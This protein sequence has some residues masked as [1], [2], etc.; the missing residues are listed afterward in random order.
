MPELP[1]VENARC[2]LVQAGLP[3][4]TFT[5]ANI[6]WAKT[7]R[8]P[9]LEEFVLGLT[10]GMV[11]AVNRRGKYILLP[12]RRGGSGTALT[13]IIHLGMTGSLRLQPKSQPEPQ[14][15]R[16]TFSLDDGRE[17]RFVDGRK[18][19][20]LWLTSDPAE[21]LPPLGPDPL[22]DE[23]TAET[24]ARSFQRRNAPVKALLLEQSIAAGIGNLYADESLFLA[25]I[26][27][28]RPASEL[29]D[30]EVSRLRDGIVA[31]LS[32]AVALYG[33]SR[34]DG[35]PDPP[36]ELNAWTIPRKAGDPCPR[37]GS[38]VDAIRL[39]GRGTRFC[40]GCQG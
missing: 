25:G 32:A 22:G 17:L 31:A 26:H 30:E 14:M 2:Y 23:F 15:L 21:V 16:H 19:G 27:P 34:A 35:Q 3:G 37:C 8:T 33:R 13:L 4:R 1:E 38:P 18:F 28:I 36:T 29:S 20:K 12:L 11:Q 39:R 6:G 24:L 5:G 10:G 40:S 7:V 9:S